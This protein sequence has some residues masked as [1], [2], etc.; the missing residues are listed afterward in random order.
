MVLVKF[1][2]EFDE[3]K[4]FYLL[5]TEAHLRGLPSGLYE[6]PDYAL[7]MFQ[8]HGIG[9]KQLNPSEFALDEAQTIRD[10]PAVEL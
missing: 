3:A 7:I 8:K 9:Y 5:A 2:S 10:T 1:A 6:V 4:G